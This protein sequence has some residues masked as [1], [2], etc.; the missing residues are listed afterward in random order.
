M[1]ILGSLSSISGR[2]GFVVDEMVLGRIFFQVLW[3][4]LPVFIIPT[5]STSIIH[6]TIDLA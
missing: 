5:F 2:V 3:F 1:F 4:P 6:P